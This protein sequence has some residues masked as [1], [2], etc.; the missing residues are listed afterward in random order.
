MR[1]WSNTPRLGHSLYDDAAPALD[2]NGQA[3]LIEQRHPHERGAARRVGLD[4]SR[5]AVPEHG[6]IMNVEIHLSVI[7]RKCLAYVGEGQP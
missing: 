1:S 6:D 7:G 3:V 4:V 5:L 2:F